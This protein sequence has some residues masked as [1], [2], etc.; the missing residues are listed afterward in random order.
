[1]LLCWRKFPN[2]CSA[3]TTD[4]LRERENWNPSKNYDYIW[5]AKE[6]KYQVQASEVK[7]GVFST[8]GR[9]VK[10]PLSYLGTGD[11]HDRPCKVRD[12]THPVWKCEV[13]K[14]VEN[15]KKWETVKKLVLCYH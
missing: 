12:Q 5:V 9:H 10:G 6:A 1:M 15:K 7:H 2:L 3:S 13:Q 4:G 14:G 8:G 11:K